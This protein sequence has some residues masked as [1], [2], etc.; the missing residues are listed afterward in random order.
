MAGDQPAEGARGARRGGR[1]PV[2]GPARVPIVEGGRCTFLFRGEAD[3]V[4]CV[5]RITG[6][7]DPLP[8]RRL[9]GHRPVVGGAGAARGLAGRIPARD[10]PRRARTSGS[11]TR[12]TRKLA[13][14]PVGTSIGRASRPGT[15]TRSGPSPTRRPGPASWSSWSCP[16]GRCAGTPG[17]PSTCRPGSAAPPRTRCWSCTTAPTTC[18]TRRPRPCWTTCMHRLEVAELVVAFLH[19][20]DRLVEY[21][22]STAH[23][24]FVTGELLPRLER[25]FPLIARP[26]GRCLMGASFGAV[27]SLSA[28]YR[29]PDTYGVA[30]AAVRLVRVHRH[31]L[32]PRRR[33]GVRPGR[34]VHQPLPGPAPARS[35]TRCSSAAACTSR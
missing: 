21:A 35:P 17:S 11:T 3:E 7:P 34:P 26:A 23:A 20:G 33:A 1:R 12:S 29:Q 28:A 16:A 2:P 19:P 14:S 13:Y 8:L 22:D 9:R 32:R 10:P 15:T 24:R 31:R 27:A 30:A 5:H 18:S 4:C 25:R 6:L